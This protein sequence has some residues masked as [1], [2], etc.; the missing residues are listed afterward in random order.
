MSTFRCT[1]GYLLGFNVYPCRYEASVV[2]QQG[3]ETIDDAITYLVA[4]FMTFIAEGRREEWLQQFYGELFPIENASVISDI[5][6]REMSV[7]QLAIHQCEQC[8]RLWLQEKA[9]ENVF[10]PYL[11][12][13]AWRGALET[14]AADFISYIDGQDFFDAHIAEVQQE[15]DLIR[16]LLKRGPTEN[17]EVTFS[18]VSAIQQYEGEHK[19]VRF[20]SEWKDTPPL[21]RFVFDSISQSHEPLLEITAREVHLGRYNA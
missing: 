12:E 6:S 16:V 20:L 9:G 8:G 13:G 5:F 17:W 14:P 4:E 10:T 2:R 15:N 7:F 11:P 18:G 1:C 21:R 19:H 3:A